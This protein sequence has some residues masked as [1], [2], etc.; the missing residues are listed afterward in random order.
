MRCLLLLCCLHLPHLHLLTGAVPPRDTQGAWGWLLWGHGPAPGEDSPPQLCLS[1]SPAA[2]PS[3][4]F[5]RMVSH[6]PPNSPNPQ[7]LQT[8]QIL[9]TPQT[10]QILNPPN[11]KPFKPSKPQIPC[12]FGWILT[13]LSQQSTTL[14][15]VAKMSVGVQVRRPSGGERQDFWDDCWD[16]MSFGIPDLHQSSVGIGGNNAVTHGNYVILHGN[17]GMRHQNNFG[18][19]GNNVRMHGKN[20][21]IHGNNVRIHGNNVGMIYGNNVIMHGNNDMIYGNNVIRQE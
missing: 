19:C 9:Q 6:H 8:P 12:F 20:I 10:L 15:N 4:P 3:R 21:G 11:L 17:N 16:D 5:L 18:I 1:S 2:Q 7:S 14:R 13:A